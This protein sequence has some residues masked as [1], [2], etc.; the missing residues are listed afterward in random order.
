MNAFMNE[1]QFWYCIICDETN[2]IE[3]KSKHI[4]SKTH[5]HKEKRVLLLRKMNLSN[6]K[7]M[8]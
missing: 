7:L 1:T 4:T 8:K 3:S 5:K 2:N 6:H